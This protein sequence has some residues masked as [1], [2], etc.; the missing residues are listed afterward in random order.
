MAIRDHKGII[1]AASYTQD[2]VK[3]PITSKVLVDKVETVPGSTAGAGSGDFIQYRNIRRREQA[4]IE[5][6]EQ[7][8]QVNRAQEELDLIRESRKEKIAKRT[9]RNA[10]KRQYKKLRKISYK[11]HSAE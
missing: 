6:M 4:R 1:I 8:Y 10:K 11:A 9:S 7:E 5:F 2:E 3:R